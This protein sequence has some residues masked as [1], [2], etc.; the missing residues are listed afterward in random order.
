MVEATASTPVC[1]EQ[2]RPNYV[3]FVQVSRI[4]PYHHMALF[5]D[6]LTI[7]WPRHRRT[8]VPRLLKKAMETE[9]SVFLRGGKRRITAIRRRSII[10]PTSLRKRR[11]LSTCCAAALNFAPCS[12]L[13]RGRKDLF[14]VRLR[15]LAL[16][17][18]C[19]SYYVAG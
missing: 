8:P 11:F 3:E 10:S 4:D 18:G 7:C 5:L 6:T 2:R 16:Q 12:R 14:S 19:M 15:G 9:N 17:G 13:G 1:P